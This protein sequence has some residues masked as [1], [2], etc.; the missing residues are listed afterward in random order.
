VST[1]A[2]LQHL[3]AALTASARQQ[4]LSDAEW[5]RRAGVPKETLCRLRSRTSCDFATLDALAAALSFEF[6]VRPAT[7]AVTEDGCW[8]R[9]VDRAFEARVL[10]VLAGGS[11]AHESWEALGPRFFVA[12][13]AVTLA[14]VRGFERA[15]YLALAER[16]HPGS[17]EPDVYRRWLAGTPLPPD[18]FLPPLLA[19]R[20]RAA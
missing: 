16:L 1:P 15:R 14:S 3:L 8:P 18:R 9:Q 4:R 12:G 10:D 17:T 6:E 19:V 2:S 13:L 11:T 5:A 7:A 20:D